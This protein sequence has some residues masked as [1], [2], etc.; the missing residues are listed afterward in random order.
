MLG[1]VEIRR[2]SVGVEADRNRCRAEP[3]RKARIR[4]HAGI[5]IQLDPAA[6]MMADHI[7][8]LFIWFR[9]LKRIIPKCARELAAKII[10]FHHGADEMRFALGGILNHHDRIP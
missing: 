3:G 5:F 2:F 4:H 8:H 6:V 10:V 1:F 7:Y 9:P